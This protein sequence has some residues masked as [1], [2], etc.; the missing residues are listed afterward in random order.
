M[1]RISTT[2]ATAA[3]I[4]TRTPRIVQS[5]L[6]NDVGDALGL[7]D[8]VLAPGG[9]VIGVVGLL[10]G[11]ARSVGRRQKVRELLILSHQ[12]QNHDANGERRHERI[13]TG[14]HSVKFKPKG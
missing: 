13:E 10:L 14:A 4:Q 2:R 12:N 7:V 6:C 5:H 3:N 9:V 11:R 1:Y 8:E